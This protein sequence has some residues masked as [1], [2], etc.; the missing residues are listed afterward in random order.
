MTDD[1]LEKRRNRILL[2][3]KITIGILIFGIL[4]YVYKLIFK[5]KP[6]KLVTIS[7]KENLNNFYDHISEIILSSGS[8]DSSYFKK[9]LVNKKFNYENYHLFNNN[10]DNRYFAIDQNGEIYRNLNKTF[11]K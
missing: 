4:R 11:F 1:Q 8:N 6:Q 3:Y 2:V 5:P 9:F 10:F 7:N